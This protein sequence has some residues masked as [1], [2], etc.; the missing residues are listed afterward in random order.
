MAAD[1]IVILRSYWEN[2]VLRLEMALGWADAL[3]CQTGRPVNVSPIHNFDSDAAINTHQF[4]FSMQV[5]QYD[6]NRG[7]IGN[8]VEAAATGPR[9]RVSKSHNF[10]QI[11]ARDS[12]IGIGEVLPVRYFRTVFCI[13]RVL[14]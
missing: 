5:S 13:W 11:L 3:T 6:I 14:P 10:W 7:G 12:S 8:D 4:A 2:K 1:Q 9:R